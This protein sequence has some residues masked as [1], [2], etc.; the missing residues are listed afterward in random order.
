MP[1]KFSIVIPIFNEEFNIKILVKEIF[2][3]LK[4]YEDEFN[5]ILVNDASTDNSLDVMTLLAK[6]YPKII[7]I[8]NNNNNLGQSFSLIEGI[9]SSIFKTIVTLDG[10]GQNNPKDIPI[11]L[12]KYFLHDNL[13]LVGGIRKKR[14]DS[15]LK[16]IS[17]KI[18]NGLRSRILKDDCSDTGCSL[19]VFDKE[20]FMTFPFFSGIHRFLP[21]LF[22]G[23]G[24]QTFFY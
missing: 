6:K 3:S 20:V 18:A 15:S 1:N 2:I 17:S 22:K 24:K 8:I 5:I 14:K 23:Y 12:T 11:L 4:E 9:K 16:I 10:D 13:F 19:K 7:K 21:S